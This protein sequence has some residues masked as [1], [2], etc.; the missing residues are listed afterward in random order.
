[1]HRLATFLLLV[2]NLPALALS[3]PSQCIQAFNTINF[4]FNGQQSTT[5]T[6]TCPQNFIVRVKDAG[7]Y[8]S[9]NPDLCSANMAPSNV[10]QLVG[11]SGNPLLSS[12]LMTCASEQ[13]CSVMASLPISSGLCQTSNGPAYVNVTYRCEPLMNMNSTGRALAINSNTGFTGNFI[14]IDSTPMALTGQYITTTN[15]Q[16]WLN[17]PP[18]VEFYVSTAVF[19][20]PDMMSCGGQYVG[21]TSIGGVAPFG[22]LCSMGQPAIRYPC[23]STPQSYVLSYVT[24]NTSVPVIFVIQVYV[25]YVTSVTIYCGDAPP[26][27]PTASVLTP[28]ST[29]PSPPM[30]SSTPVSGASTELALPLI[31]IILII[32]FGFLLLVAIIIILICCC[33]KRRNK[34]KETSPTTAVRRQPN[35]IVVD[36]RKN[37][38]S[39]YGSNAASIAD[40]V[41]NGRGPGQQLYGYQQMRGGLRPATGSHISHEGLSSLPAFQ[42]NMRPVVYQSYPTSFELTPQATPPVVVHQPIIQRQA[43]MPNLLMSDA[44]VLH[45]A[46]ATPSMIGGGQQPII[47]HNTNYGHSNATPIYSS[48]IQIT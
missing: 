19:L 30:S 10:C 33:M 40:D 15:G 11:G 31:G 47:S 7:M 37:A 5:V 13:S 9:V 38:G 42:S 14:N 3:Q 24:T 12:L 16:C 27:N 36:T 43:S 41:I 4:C 28:S 2:I 1:M 17:V 44:D 39:M 35:V 20:K 6:L 34:E 29:P 18:N 46:Y 23:Q 21:V 8:V 45:S 25:K 22:K 26:D 48:V 32:V